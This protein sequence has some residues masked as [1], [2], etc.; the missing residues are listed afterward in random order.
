M[1]QELKQVENKLVE[2]LNKNLPDGS[3]NIVNSNFI[4]PPVSNR[5]FRLELTVYIPAFI[6]AILWF[7]YLGRWIN[8]LKKEG[9]KQSAKAVV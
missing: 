2:T 9:R 4:P 7:I 5:I 6:I 3:F 1:V 8:E